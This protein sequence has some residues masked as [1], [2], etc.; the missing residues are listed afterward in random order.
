[1]R[2]KIFRNAYVSELRNEITNNIDFYKGNESLVFSN[3]NILQSNRVMVD[4]TP[5]TLGTNIAEDVDN[6]IKVYEYLPIDDTQASD[7]RLW[8]YMTHVTFRDY[9]M[10]RW[11]VPQNNSET[12]VLSRW[13]LSGKSA[14]S[15]R[16][17]AISRL[18]WAVR[19][20]I[21]PWEDEYF[22]ILKDNDK[23]VYTR[24]LFLTEDISQGLIE[25][26]LGW[27]QPILIAIL[28]YFKRNPDLAKNRQLS[29]S[30]IKEVN[31]LLGYRK[32]MALNLEDII[33]E[34]EEIAEEI[35][36]IS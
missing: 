14:R 36:R 33:I 8:T 16:R 35:K 13:F 3:D 31:L 30:L 19:L 4:E 22:A 32:I 27:S 5:P 17:N 29:R 7:A 25:R 9:V 11:P 28:D 12:N 18:W 24:T 23:Y 10:S 20:T 26:R 1:M 6:A 21:A 2:L 15:L 34:V